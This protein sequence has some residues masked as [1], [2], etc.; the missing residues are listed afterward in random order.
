MKKLST[1]LLLLSVRVIVAQVGI[2]TTTPTAQLDVNGTLRV[3]T[4]VLT[5]NISAAKDS[6]LVVDNIGNVKRV[7]SKTV[8]ESNL[9]S[10]VKGS[11]NSSSDV[12]LTLLADACKIGFDFVEFD[13]NNEF[14]TTQSEFTAKQDGIYQ[15]SVQ[16]KAT[17]AIAVATNF[18][19]A[20][21][22]NGTVV[23]RTSFA[24]VGVVGVNVTPPVRT[25]TTLVSLNTGDT[26]SFNVLS[27]LLSLN[28]LGTREDCNFTINQ[29]R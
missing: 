3:R 14:N 8:F 10:C 9:K 23:N 1:I 16:I 19:V 20:I 11:F 26:I 25:V 5:N 24:N 12:T 21:L 17:S 18:G 13:L 4:T 6:I 28:L 7:S 29:I 15:V 2:G 27:T 22:K